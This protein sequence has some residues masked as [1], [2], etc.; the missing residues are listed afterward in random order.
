MFPSLKFCIMERTNVSW[1]WDSPEFVQ[2]KA[3][4]KENILVHVIF[5][6]ELHCRNFWYVIRS[7]KTRNKGHLWHFQLLTSS[8]PLHTK[9]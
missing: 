6:N 3:Y 1:T 9:L 5:A 7:D 8:E 2:L 4:K